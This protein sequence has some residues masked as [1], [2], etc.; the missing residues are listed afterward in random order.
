MS[1]QRG[2]EEGRHN[3]LPSHRLLPDDVCARFE[4]RA[5]VSGITQ[6]IK[7]S[8]SSDKFPIHRSFKVGLYPFSFK[9]THSR[10]GSSG[11]FRFCSTCTHL[12]MSQYD[13][14]TT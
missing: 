11:S 2:C 5:G 1:Y 4:P 6:G 10:L 13:V 3:D 12:N 8:A 9:A 14:K 7:R